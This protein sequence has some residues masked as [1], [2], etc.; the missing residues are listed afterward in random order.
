MQDPET[1]NVGR[2]G[3]RDQPVG[4]QRD[5]AIAA[6]GHALSDLEHVVGVERDL[7]GEDE[8]GA[9]VPGENDRAVGPESGLRRLP[10]CLRG[11]RCDVGVGGQPAELCEIGRSRARRREQRDLR[12]VFL[13]RL[14]I[15]GEQEIV[16]PGAL[17]GDRA[18]H[19][20]RDD[21]HPGFRR[22]GGLCG[23]RG[24]R[25]ADR[26]AGR[27]EQRGDAAGCVRQGCRR[28]GGLDRL[29]GRLAF[30]FGGLL[31]G[32]FA[33]EARLLDQELVTQQDRHR[34]DDREEEVALIHDRDAA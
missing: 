8:P 3:P 26:S 17:E 30:R 20:A 27:R 9:V 13:Q 23:C 16:D 18:L 14:A 19:P 10:Q 32:A 5:G 21:L 25:N 29:A 12:A 24:A 15:V 7:L 31:G 34:D 11:R 1:E 28:P 4:P 22:G 2:V 33:F 6:I